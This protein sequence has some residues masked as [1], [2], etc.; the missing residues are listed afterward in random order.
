[1][2]YY[3]GERERESTCKPRCCAASLHTRSITVERERERQPA[4][5]VVAPLHLHTRSITLERERD[6]L[7]TPLLRRYIFIHEVL[8]WR[9]RETT[10]KP[11]CC[12]ATSSYTK[13]YGGER[14]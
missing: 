8:R 7:Q 14:E 1:M 4:N 3:G 10:C 12:A 2:G 9:E 6:N 5:P 13:Y 11:R